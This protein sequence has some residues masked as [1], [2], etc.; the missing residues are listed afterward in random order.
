MSVIHNDS[1]RMSYM[2]EV[3]NREAPSMTIIFTISVYD[4]RFPSWIFHL[5]STLPSNYGVGA[6]WIVLLCT[7]TYF[8]VLLD[9]SAYF[10]VL[11]RTSSHF[12]TFEVQKYALSPSVTYTGCV[13][14]QCMRAFASVGF[15]HDKQARYMT[16]VGKNA[17]DASY[18]NVGG[19]LPS[20]T[21]PHDQQAQY[22]PNVGKRTPTMSSHLPSWVFLP[23]QASRLHIQY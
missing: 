3:N 10:Y 19:R 20:W 6:M 12:R 7:S 22:T 18:F 21:F 23:Q 4:R 15:H 13:L 8:F 11:L 9:T 5:G 16:H 14:F 17:L 2:I 1:A